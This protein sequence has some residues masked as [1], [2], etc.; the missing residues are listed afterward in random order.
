M[1][2]TNFLEFFNL[3]NYLLTNDIIIENQ[4]GFSLLGYP[5]FSPDLLLPVFDPPNFQLLYLNNEKFLN[6][7]PISLS[8]NLNSMIDM[9]ALNY[10]EKNNNSN[11]SKWYVLMDS[12]DM[13]DQGWY[14]SWNFHSKKWKSKH[15]VVRR[16]FWIKL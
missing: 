13:D 4:R 5:L 2:D 6:I 16:R 11:D 15:G 7:L 12:N 8:K 10:N 9:Y 3:N 1:Q 14:Y